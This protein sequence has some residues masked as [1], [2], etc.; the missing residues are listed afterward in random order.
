MPSR[1]SARTLHRVAAPHHHNEA[2]LAWAKEGRDAPLPDR[3]PTILLEKQAELQKQFITLAQAVSVCG[4]D[5]G[6][7]ARLESIRSELAVVD[8]DLALV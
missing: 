4:V 3:N 2:V 5:A 6:S 7:V 8:R 1:F